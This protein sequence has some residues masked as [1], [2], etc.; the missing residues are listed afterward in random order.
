MS[1]TPRR[2]TP[3]CSAPCTSILPS[4]S[5]SRLCSV[6]SHRSRNS[7]ASGELTPARRCRRPGPS[8][9]AQTNLRS[10][11]PPFH[12][13]M[14]ELR[15]NVRACCEDL[16]VEASFAAECVVILR[17]LIPRPVATYRILRYVRTLTVLPCLFRNIDFGLIH[18]THGAVAMM[19]PAP[20]L[21]M[22]AKDGT[23][24]DGATGSKLPV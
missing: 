4:P 9:H 20:S 14:D 8:A 21:G 12:P 10:F 13:S 16:D 18:I 5:S 17:R 2:P 19:I 7:L 6:V 3:S 23:T 15:L 24:G 1:C 11:W 22:N